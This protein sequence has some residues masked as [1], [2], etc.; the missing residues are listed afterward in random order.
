MHRRRCEREVGW[1]FSQHGYEAEVTKGSGDGGIDIFL[2]KNGK[3]SVVQCKRFTH[4]AGP[5]V[6]R[7][8]YGTMMAGNY[9][10]AFVVCPA[11]FSDN[12][13]DFSKNKKVRLIGLKGIMEM[14]DAVPDDI[15]SSGA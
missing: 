14:V 12:A 15:R 13:Y 7:D 8:M 10:E 3:V 1:L 2:K 11:G 4:K 5:A 9:E 6:V